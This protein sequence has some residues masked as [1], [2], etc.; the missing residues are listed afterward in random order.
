MSSPEIEIYQNSGELGLRLAE[1][2][3]EILGQAI[4]QK[5]SAS[6]AL[7][8]GSTPQAAYRLLASDDFRELIEW[9]KVEWFFGDERF[10]P[11]NDDRSNEKMARE[12]ILGPLGVSEERI[13]G[14]VRTEDAVTSAKLYEELLSEKLGNGWFDL[15]L[16]GIGDDGHTLSLFPGETIPSGNVAATKAPV[17]ATERI[18]LTPGPVCNSSL[19]ILA[20]AG[21]AKAIPL[22]DALY[23]E[24]DWLRVPSQSVI[25]HATSLVILC[26]QAAAAKLTKNEIPLE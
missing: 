17:V 15:V 3:V 8:G 5:G 18:T 19:V 25:R 22:A 14:M 11:V 16:V 23:G 26:D 10:V 24:E 4:D 9:S 1:L 12:C 6:I 21:A 7:A 2:T 13:H 20:A